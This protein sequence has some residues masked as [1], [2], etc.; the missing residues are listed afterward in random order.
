MDQSI[1]ICY[2]WWIKITKFV[3]WNKIWWI[4]I[5]KTKFV[6]GQPRDNKICYF[7]ILLFWW[8]KNKITKYS[9]L[10]STPRD[11]AKCN[12]CQLIGNPLWALRLWET[13]SAPINDNGIANNPYGIA[14]SSDTSLTIPGKP[15]TNEPRD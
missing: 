10:R 7:V 11:P 14:Y 4:K 3:I 15:E 13:G 2:F 5:T 12:E 6:L 9:I 1:K 8:I